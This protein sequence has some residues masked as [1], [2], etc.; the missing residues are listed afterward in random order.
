MAT[1]LLRLAGPMQAWGTDSKFETR[2]TGREPSKS[3][4]VGLLAAALGLRRDE[5][6]ALAQLNRLRYGVR[7]DQEGKWLVDYQTVKQKGKT[8]SADRSYVTWRYYLADA[9]FL[10]GLESDD[11]SFLETL[12]EALQRP[13][14][15]LFL[16]RRS[17][18]PTLP[19]CL[20]IREAGLEQ[21]L[22][23]EPSLLPVWKKQ[24]A[25]PK[26]LVMDVDPSDPGGAYRQDVAL[27]FSP[28]HRQFGYRLA[29]EDTVTLPETLTATQHD[30]FAEL[31]GD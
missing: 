22:R 13:A 26:R 5:E 1:L 23:S 14:F 21:A 31:G 25:A 18:P 27:S 4:V 20:G 11:L 17:C 29:K 3:G 8:S 7:V 30:P 15:P 6:D 2:K 12:N 16:G 28:L 24:H 19:L 9:I 10:A